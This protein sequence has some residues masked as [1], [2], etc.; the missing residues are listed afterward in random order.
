MW[1][2]SGVTKTKPSETLFVM[3]PEA[4]TAAEV[5]EL[6]EASPGFMGWRTV[7]RMVFVDFHTT[8]A[9]TAAMRRFQAYDA[10]ACN[11]ATGAQDRRRTP[12]R[13]A[14]DFDKDS[15][16]KRNRQYERQRE[17]ALRDA[18]ERSETAY[19]CTVCGT[20][21]FSL[22]DSA[23]LSMQPK[24]KTDGSYAIDTAA[25]LTD[26]RVADGGMK[27]L[28]RAKG[29]ERQYRLHCCDCCVALGYVSAPLSMVSRFTY[30]FQDAVNEVAPRRPV[31]AS[32]LS[33]TAPTAVD[34]TGVDTA[35][36]AAVAK[37]VPGQV[38]VHASVG[39][40]ADSGDIQRLTVAE[41]K[42]AFAA[43]A[44]RTA[45]ASPVASAK[46]DQS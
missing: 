35:T 13:L 24:R 39:R 46:A 21:A 11:R 41:I 22:R 9:S 12:V 15:R 26:L 29:V 20:R 30:V 32:C 45:L 5:G 25:L 28:R 37:P 31:A 3:V 40:E 10:F 14:I 16:E 2:G 1:C 43:T 36:A 6:F 33:S 34:T 4:V 8:Q 19:A 23:K 27:L 7:R 38:E 42:A 18:R 44:L 17:C